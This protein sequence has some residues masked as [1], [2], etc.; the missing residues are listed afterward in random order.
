VALLSGKTHVKVIEI[1]RAVKIDGVAVNPGGILMVTR[2][3]LSGSRSSEPQRWLGRVARWKS[4]TRQ[5]S[6]EI[7]S[8]LSFTEV[9]KMFAK[10]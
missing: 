4:R 1:G 5:G 10:L 7:R 8:G 9:L 3:D 2:P 6:A